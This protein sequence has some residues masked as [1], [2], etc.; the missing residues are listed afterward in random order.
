MSNASIFVA[1]VLTVVLLTW[2]ILPIIGN[3]KKTVKNTPVEQQR[4]NL[5]QYYARVLQNLHDIDEDFATGKLD[6]DQ[7][8][9]SRETWIA[10]G[11]HALKALD[12]LNAG[13]P[14]M[15]STDDDDMLDQLT[16]P[17]TEAAIFSTS[18]SEN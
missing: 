10:H 12:S 1:F 11:I 14:S 17:N 9:L 13:E 4:T 8:R 15:D 5:Q 18:E 3:S 6:E 16:E 2:L 7:H